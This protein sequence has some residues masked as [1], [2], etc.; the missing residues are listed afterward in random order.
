[1]KLVYFDAKGL[2]ENIRII[3]TIANIPFDDFRY[4]IE[5]IDSEKHIYKRDLY[6]KDKQDNHFVLSMN[7]LPFLL[8]D[9]NTIIAQSKT[10]ER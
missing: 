4:P 10:I 2:A 7:K 6:D 8:L 1:M 9:D 5:I 3:F